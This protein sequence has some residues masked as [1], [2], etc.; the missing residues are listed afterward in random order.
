MKNIC[1]KNIKIK[2]LGNLN[3]KKLSKLMLTQQL[4]CLP[5]LYE[6]VGQ[7]ALDP[8]YHGMQI[9]STDN[10]GLKNYLG[11]SAHYIHPLDKIKMI[12]KINVCTQILT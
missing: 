6:G 7:S 8:A 4:F 12:H 2:Y 1:K 5:S 3:S 11:S 9:V 10:T